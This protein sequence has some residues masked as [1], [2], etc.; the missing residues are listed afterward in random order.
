MRILGTFARAHL[1]VVSVRHLGFTLPYASWAQGCWAQ[2]V[3]YI[4][5]FFT[6]LHLKSGVP[7]SCFAHW[8]SSSK[9][10]WSQVLGV[11]RNRRDKSAHPFGKAKKSPSRWCAM[12][13]QTT[14]AFII[15]I[16]NSSMYQTWFTIYIK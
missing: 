14:S 15:M 4:H 12:Y 13:Y 5:T 3:L 9:L 8:Y 7:D 10:E 6:L 11:E 1:I 16:R 2:G